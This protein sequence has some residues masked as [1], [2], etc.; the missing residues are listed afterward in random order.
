MQGVTLSLSPSSPKKGEDE[1]ITVNYDKLRK[2]PQSIVYIYESLKVFKPLNGE[3]AHALDTKLSLLT[4]TN[5]LMSLDIFI[6]WQFYHFFQ[7]TTSEPL[8]LPV[9]LLTKTTS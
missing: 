2:C 6:H 5:F 3:I 4:I 1:T 9:C 8:N 7:L